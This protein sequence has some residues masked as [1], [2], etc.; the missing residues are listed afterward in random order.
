[1]DLGVAMGNP[2]FFFVLPHFQMIVSLH[3]FLEHQKRK[4]WS[5]H[6]KSCKD[7]MKYEGPCIFPYF[8]RKSQSKDCISSDSKKRFHCDWDLAG[9]ASSLCWACRSMLSQLRSCF[10]GLIWSEHVWITFVCNHDIPWHTMTYHD[11]PWHTVTYHD[12]PWH[13]MTYHDIPWHT[14]TYHDIPWHIMTYHDIPWHT[15]TMISS[16]ILPGPG[17][18]GVWPSQPW[19]WWQQW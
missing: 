7:T 3:C 19:Q 1:M 12:I 11:I 9:W 15:M 2:V 8:S 13:T 4:L 14:M 5:L 18:D 6:V 10:E 17:H 16:M